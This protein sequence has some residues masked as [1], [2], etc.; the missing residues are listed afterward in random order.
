MRVVLDA[1][2]LVSAVVAKGAPHRIVNRWLEADEF[3][4][5][6]CPALIAEVEDVLG[7]PKIRKRLSA[8]LAARYLATLQRSALGGRSGRGRRDYP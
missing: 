4:V 3:E 8:E 6:I 1:N 5:I 2:V 7:R